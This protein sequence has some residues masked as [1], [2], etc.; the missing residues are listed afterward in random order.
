MDLTSVF[1]IEHASSSA[2]HWGHLEYQQALRS[3]ERVFLVAE[4]APEEA[5]KHEIVGFLVASTATQE[6]E[7][8]NIAVAP[9][10]RRRGIGRALMNALIQHARLSGSVEIR[11]EIRASN[12]TAQYLARSVGFLEEGRR[13][14]YYRDPREDARLFRYLVPKP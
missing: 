12:T 3:R 2:A 1:G 10:S 13:K 11:Q 14:G 9:A 4:M 6:W 5:A 8:E 7:L